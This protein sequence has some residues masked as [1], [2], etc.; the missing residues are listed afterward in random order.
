M[1]IES[2][3]GPPRDRVGLHHNQWSQVAACAHRFPSSVD[4]RE[5]KSQ[6]LCNVASSSDRAYH[7]IRLCDG[8]LRSMMVEKPEIGE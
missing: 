4:D 7:D 6:Q 5:G 2:A 8:K 1:F 3:C